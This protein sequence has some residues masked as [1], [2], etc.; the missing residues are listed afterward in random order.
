VPA[1]QLVHGR[2]AA[3][4]VPVEYVPAAQPAQ[5]RSEVALPGALTKLP[6]AHVLHVAHDAAFVPLE[7]EP[8]AQLAHERSLVD[9]P[10][11]AT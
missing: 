2:H 4:F 7:Y 5:V 1:T 10:A 3:A 9:E 6:A 8:I 11:D